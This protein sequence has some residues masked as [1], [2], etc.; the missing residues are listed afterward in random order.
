[1][2]SI[3]L[4][5]RPGDND[6]VAGRLHDQL[7]ERFG[8]DA[9]VWR[10]PGDPQARPDLRDAVVVVAL[11]GP[12]WL[13]G[14]AGDEEP[15]ARPDDPVREELEAAMRRRLPIIPALP[16]GA[17]LPQAP[18][19]PPALRPLAEQTPTP[20]R[21]D[22]DFRRDAERLAERLAR[23]VAPLTA[24][25]GVRG[26][27]RQAF[28]LI[29]AV[30]LLI[31]A[32]G[33]AGVVYTLRAGV[34]GF[35]ALAAPTPT[36]TPIVTRTPSLVTVIQDPL[37]QVIVYA[38]VPPSWQQNISKQCS[39]AA[40]GYQVLGGSKPGYFSLCA[41]PAITEAGNERINVT[42]R[43]TRADDP[44]A[45]YGLDFHSSGGL[46]TDGYEVAISPTGEWTLFD[47]SAG[48][49]LASGTSAAIHTSLGAVNTLTVDSYGATITV[50][51]NGARLGQ[52]SAGTASA[53]QLQFIVEHGLVAVYTNLTVA[54]Y[55]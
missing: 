41:G 1:M 36:V 52:V 19:L 25:R 20:L 30:A 6:A 29:A 23:Y 33:V 24:T 26:L 51:V 54:R 3:Y 15:L 11:I 27:S 50:S 34:G 47:V 55:Q 38:G 7:A 5:Y 12:R 17:A 46:N 10:V 2:A 13:R 21:D 18:Y 37:S 8:R 14:V 49:A 43:L 28:A 31:V 44:H 4:S 16:Q 9:V 53:G 35:S 42:M 48:K 45:F 39:F 40:G 32:L 22:P